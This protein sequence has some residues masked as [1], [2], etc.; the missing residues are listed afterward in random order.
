MA[1]ACKTAELF[2]GVFTCSP[3]VEIYYGFFLSMTFSSSC[4]TLVQ[5]KMDLTRTRTSG[6]VMLVLGILLLA[7]ILL[8]SLH[9]L[10][11]A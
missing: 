6:D 7:S 10:V 8:T 11:L 4:S 5:R 1:I 3:N 2:G 9:L